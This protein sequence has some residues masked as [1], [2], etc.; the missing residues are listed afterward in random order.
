L[1]AIEAQ[2]GDP[3]AAYAACRQALERGPNP[4]DR[5]V[6]LVNTAE[7]ARGLARFDEAEQLL[8]EATVHFAPAS[9]AAP[10]LELVELYVGQGRISDAQD[11]L[12]EMLAW[13]SRQGAAIRAQNDAR[14]ARASV[15][16]L[17]AAGRSPE[18]VPIAEQ[19]LRTPDRA[20]ERSTSR[21]DLELD[22]AVIA[23][24]ACLDA[25]ERAIESASWA[26]PGAR[27]RAWLAA[28]RL[29]ACAWRAE[30]QAAALLATRLGRYEP[31]ALELPEWLEPDTVAI[32]GAGA[33]QTLSAAPSR[34]QS[35]G[36]AQVYAAEAANQRGRAAEALE[37]A[38]MALVKLPQPERLAR[39]R[40]AVLAGG[41]ALEL[42]DGAAAAELFALAVELDGGALRRAGRALPVSI[43]TDDSDVARIAARVLRGSPR[44]RSVPGA[45]RLELRGKPG[46]ARACL[47]R[48]S[49][50]H[51]ACA[52]IDPLADET[53]LATARR[54]AAA[55]HAS[56]FAPRDAQ[57][58]AR[59]DP[60]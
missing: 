22:A 33:V 47:L 60:A 54:L 24:A 13:Q 45:L 17:L 58:S 19:A 23:R 48:A 52:R 27:L 51:L 3:Q 59:S 46:Q 42:G 18:A 39:A 53:P 38:R 41:A 9:L 1:C 12:H 49:G 28:A 5:A 11:A 50:V 44:L 57:P 30:R 26:G 31:G 43:E 34:R 55:F 2:A 7:A 4:A 37:Q 32:A 25:A 36:Y 35:S 8:R 15:L 20:G 6:R 40:S 29:R 56:A 14:H 21:A 10:W 16:F